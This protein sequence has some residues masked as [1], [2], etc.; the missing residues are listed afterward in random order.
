MDERLRDIASL[1]RTAK[2][3]AAEGS[4]EAALSFL[5]SQVTQA[6]CPPRWLGQESAAAAREKVEFGVDAINNVESIDAFPAEPG[7]D[8]HPAAGAGRH[9]LKH[10]GTGHPNMDDLE[11]HGA[12]IDPRISELKEIVRKSA[13][14]CSAPAANPAVEGGHAEQAIAMALTGRN[15]VSEAAADRAAAAASKIRAAIT[16]IH[17]DPIPALVKLEEV[18]NSIQA[19]DS[20]FQWG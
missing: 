17:I 4:E 19:T 12:Y 14:A 11:Q 16:T 9:G 1:C 18:L 8:R 2:A 20:H 10:T 13:I 15:W 7:P 3:R 5:K 6:L